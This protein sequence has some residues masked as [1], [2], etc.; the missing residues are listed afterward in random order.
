MKKTTPPLLAAFMLLPM[1]AQAQNAQRP[2]PLDA[3]APVAPL[4]YRSAFSGF[5]PLASDAPPLSWREANDAVER[6]GGWRAYAREAS[7]PAPA[8]SVP[9]ASAP[10]ASPPAAPASAPRATRPA[11]PAPGHRH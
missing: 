3:K 9:G 2:D 7:A 8:A 11:T 1:A 10:A 5:K 6:I 4:I